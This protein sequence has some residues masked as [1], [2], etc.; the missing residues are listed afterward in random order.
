MSPAATG[1]DCFDLARSD[2]PGPPD[3]VIKSV[4]GEITDESNQARAFSFLPLAWSLGS[5][6]GCVTYPEP[7]FSSVGSY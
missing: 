7:R 2:L 6:I 5:V 3:S 4:L 1:A